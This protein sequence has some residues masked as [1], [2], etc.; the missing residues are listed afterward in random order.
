M[1][2]IKRAET[3]GDEA[4]CVLAGKGAHEIRLGG[5]VVGHGERDVGLQ[6]VAEAALIDQVVVE[7]FLEKN[8]K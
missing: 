2:P 1:Q 7:L 4:A 6:I 8:V 3:V 5:R